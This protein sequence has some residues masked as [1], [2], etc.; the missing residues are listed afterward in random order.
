MPFPLESLLWD[1]LVIDDDGIE[2]EILSFAIKPEL[3]EK[4]TQS[5]FGSG[6]VPLKLTP[7]PAL[8]YCSLKGKLEAEETNSLLINFGA[9][10][11]NLTFFS[12]SGFLLRSFTQGGGNL[13]E[14][15]ASSFGVNHPKAEEL[16]LNFSSAS[17]AK[18]SN[19]NATTTLQ[20]VHENFLNKS[21]Q[22]ISR[23]V[24]T[25]KRLKKGKAPS[26]LIITGRAT[27]SADLVQS[28]AQSQTQP[29]KYFD[30]FKQINISDEI[31]DEDRAILP[32]VCS[33]ILG[34]ANILLLEPKATV[35]NLMPK[36]KLR[37]LENK[38]RLPW[39]LCSALI[40]SLIPLPWY[41]NLSTT[42][43]YLS[44]ETIKLKRQTLELSNKLKFSQKEN[45]DL[46]LLK[47]INQIAAKHVTQLDSLS[48]R[49]FSLQGLLNK[50]QLQFDPKINQ[51]AW[52]DRFEFISP[53]RNPVGTNLR[54]FKSRSSHTLA[55][56]T[57]R[58][59]VKPDEQL[60]DMEEDNRRLALIEESGRI[61]ETLTK[62]IA[63]ID[64]VLK[65]SKKTFSI[66]G[67]G[68]LY[69]RQFTHFEFE[70][71]LD[72]EK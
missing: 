60:N 36:A 35:L 44:S 5:I 62:A 56:I 65:V 42:D 6:V 70:L 52:I 7:G 34:L 43:D 33:E 22:E 64:Q 19:D 69:N 9:K 12:S 37:A 72:L 27:K 8:D 14:A 16:K 59:L 10:S 67:K 17:Q 50:L 18:D 29:I 3:I 46:V 21:M 26:Q 49:A 40:I 23:S 63:S 66:E 41:L 11:T 1:F 71:E 48:K 38:K 4:L 39:F 58:Y 24:V 28:L 31:E 45:S 57:G 13:T 51:N 47:S 54:N 61:Q 30:P 25:Y 20:A 15:I 53:D 55:R 32:Y 2:Q 68:D